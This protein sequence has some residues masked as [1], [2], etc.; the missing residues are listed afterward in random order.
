MQRVSAILVV[1]DGATWLPEVVASLASQTR[2]ID[3]LIAIDTGSIDSSLKLLKGARIPV[4]S[5]PRETGFGAA[6]AVAVEKLPPRALDEWLWIIHDDCAPASGALAALLAAVEDRPQVVM[7]GPKLLGWHDRTHLLEIGISIATNGARWTGLEESEYDQ[8]QHDG[9]T[10]V[11][12]VSTAGA[13][14][15]RDVFEDLGGFDLNLELFRDD[16]D[17]GWR[18][19]AAG[20][21]VVAVTDAVAYHAQASANERRSVDVKGALLHRPLLLDRQNAAYVLL[22][23]ATWW[24]LPLLALQLFTSALFRAA[25]YLF[26]KLPGYAGD[27]LLAIVNLLL[28]PGELIK[29]RRDRKTTRLVSAHVI[30]QFIPSRARQLRLALERSRAAIR[31][32]ILQPIQKDDNND[33]L[34]DLPTESELEEEDLLAPIASR[35]WSTVFRRPFIVAIFFLTVL[36]VLWS[37]NRIGAVSGGTLA[38]SP[39]GA[40][41]LWDFYFAPWHEVGLGSK[42]A[43]PLWIPL[44][45]L[46]SILT[47][48]NVEVFISLFFILTP[49]ILF[50]SMHH[51]LK[52]ISD[53]RSLTAVAALLFAISPV[54]VSAVNSGRIGLIVLMATAPFL[55]QRAFQWRV[56][57]T[58][59]VR[60][61]SALSLAL[62]FVFSFVPLLLLLLVGL[63]LVAII[64]DFDSFRIDQNQKLL[65]SRLAR[66]AALIFTPILLTIPWSFQLITSP[67]ELLLDIGL[68]SSGGGP[69][70][71]FLANPGGAGSLPWWLI[72]PVTFLLLIAL[73]SEHRSRQIA[74]L[75]GSL[76]VF[77]TFLSTFSFAGKGTGAP[78][79]LHAGVFTALATLAATYAAVEMLNSAREKL[80]SSHLSYRHLAASGL[81]IASIVYGVGASAWIISQ[82]PQAPLQ[83]AQGE[84]LPPFLAIESQSK[85]LV[86]RERVIES[87]PVLNY[88]IA[89][90]GD[91]SLGEADVV[92][93]EIPEIEL[94]VTGLADGS[95][96]G[97]SKVLGSFGIT[98]VFLKAPSQGTLAQT[99]DGLGGFTR[100]SS[101]EAGIVWKV[102]GATGNLVLTDVNGKSVQLKPTSIPDEYIVPNPGVVTLTQSYSRSWYL[103]QDG[104]RLTRI[105]S[106]LLLPQF[107]VESPGPV[108]LIHDGS[109][110]RGW[111]SLQFIILLTVLTLAAPSG[112]RKRE[113]SDREIS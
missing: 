58:F 86:I 46:G 70:L 78:T 16:I 10:D 60:A 65:N 68:V 54:A 105:Q 88:Y 102:S 45:A 18:V 20:H 3:Q 7:A 5:L 13:L 75:G 110:R 76:I 96:I 89:R 99:I 50:A 39:E 112:R 49:I 71:A 62:A 113:I 4:I 84:V 40:R 107:S 52:K 22:A 98:Y 44:L 97:S 14:I 21:S 2:A 42:S 27:E 11:L 59:S 87:V 64:K 83:S 111:I 101:T 69:N 26:A 61:I 47:F 67:R 85:T 17:F 9:V 104:K 82:A 72:S 34:I 109:V 91:V 106:E 25:G 81:V 57:E 48:G 51:L 79:A 8:G 23:N 94:A 74:V 55:I 66:R 29:A 38:P 24:L 36:T 93:R 37:R 15:R 32:L 43:S 73:F 53:N 1:H 103:V 56:I 92:P 80:A 41:H 30:S 90:G 12:A 35:K 33:V 100:A 63:S 19:H 108:L 95:G 77:G 28:K 31:D 6:V